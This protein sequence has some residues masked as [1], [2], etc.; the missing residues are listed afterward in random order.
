MLIKD[1]EKRKQ[2]ETMINAMSEN[3]LIELLNGIDSEKNT[4]PE[5]QHWK[6]INQQVVNAYQSGHYSKGI[7]F[8]E[9]AYQYALKNF[10]ETDP[11]T[12]IS[13]NNLALL[14]TCFFS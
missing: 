7:A 10:G 13:I 8:A 6:E 3:E 5:R 2:M 9:K 1:P 12:L 4:P 14:Q 11:D